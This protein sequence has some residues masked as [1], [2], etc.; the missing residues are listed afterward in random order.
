MVLTRRVLQ[1][2]TFA[3][4]SQTESKEKLESAQKELDDCR[5]LIQQH[6]AKMKSLTENMKEV[7]P[8]MMEIQ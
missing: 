7:R 4:R 2:P 8:F 6:E 5:L 1:L 3:F